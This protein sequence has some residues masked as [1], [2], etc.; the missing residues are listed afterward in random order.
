MQVA[1]LP[2]ADVPTQETH[3]NLAGTHGACSDRSDGFVEADS[4]QHRFEV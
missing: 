2:L 1:N 3:A 4:L